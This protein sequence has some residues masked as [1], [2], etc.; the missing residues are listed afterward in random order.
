M[1]W[2]LSVLVTGRFLAMSLSSTFP[3]GAGQKAIN[4]AESHSKPLDPRPFIIVPAKNFRL[5]ALKLG[6]RKVPS[7]GSFLG[8]FDLRVSG[9]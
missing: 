2:I 6:T 9:W 7:R 5:L 8:I 4:G 1:A 3:K